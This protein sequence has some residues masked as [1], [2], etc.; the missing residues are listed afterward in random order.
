MNHS[1]GAGG[2]AA[3]EVLAAIAGAVRLSHS[4]CDAD[5]QLAQA[6]AAVDVRL[7]E[8]AMER[9]LRRLETS[10]GDTNALLALVILGEAHPEV[11]ALF[12]VAPRAEAERLVKRL[13]RE[14]SLEWS[15]AILRSRMAESREV[16]EGAPLRSRK[17]SWNVALPSARSLKLALSVGLGLLLLL[18]GLRRELDLRAEW[19]AIPEAKAGDLESVRVRVTRLREL[20]EES[21][22]WVGLPAAATEQLRLEG[23]LRRLSR[24]EEQRLTGLRGEAR[25]RAADAHEARDKALL[26]LEAGSH[27]E[28][29]RWFAYAIERGGA[30]WEGAAQAERDLALLDGA[31][32]SR[33]SYGAGAGVT[34]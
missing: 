15:S 1:P 7:A 3:D 18:G 2:L 16:R 14:G 12:R 8:L 25:R 21:G 6:R 19:A 22:A 10:P 13:Q 11:A 30:E 33:G 29:R 9:V 31:V 24:L 28:A 26:A 34:R 23:E 4:P 5:R 32:M 20:I 17:R 27:Q